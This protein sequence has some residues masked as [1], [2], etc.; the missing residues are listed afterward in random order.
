[1]LWFYFLPTHQ[2][3]L[4]L[5]EL[6]VTWAYLKD[7][8]IFKL[9]TYKT[10]ARTQICRASWRSGS[11]PQSTF[12][13]A[14]PASFTYPKARR[15]ESVIDDYHGTKIADPYVWLEDPD[16]E[17]TKGFV[18]EQNAITMPYLADCEIRDNFKTRSAKSF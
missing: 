6:A 11:R 16:S 4:I 15:D 1:M 2:N 10:L 13:M 18:E 8:A 17:E 14:V 5:L 9:V 3:L 12:K 7:I